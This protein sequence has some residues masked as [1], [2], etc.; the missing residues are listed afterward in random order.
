MLIRFVVSNF[1]SFD[2]ETEFNM[3]AGSLK[4]HKHHVYDA[5]KVEVLKAGAIYGANGAGKSNLI[6]AISFLAEAVKRGNLN[7]SV[8]YQKFKLNETNTQKPVSFEVEIAIEKKIY[9]YG[10]SFQSNHIE[11]EWLYES[12]VTTEDKMIFERKRTTH[13]TIDIVVAKKFQKTEKQKLLIELMKENL[14]KDNE[15]LISKYDNLKIKEITDVYE[16]FKSNLI[17]IFPNSRPMHLIS[18]FLA[19]KHFINN[20]FC[21]FDIGIS[22]LKLTTIDFDKLLEK[23]DQT[24]KDEIKILLDE[25]KQLVP[26]IAGKGIRTNTLLAKE[27]NQYTAKK[28]VTLH[29]NAVNSMI[30]FDIEEESD[31][32][33]RLLDFIPM[34]HSIVNSNR[35]FIIDE[36]E[37]NLHP[38]LIQTL[39]RKIMADA[40][41]KGQLIFT[42]HYVGLMDLDIFRQDEIWFAEKDRNKGSTHLYS[43]NDFK[44]RHD[45]DIEKGY[46]KGRFGAVPFLS[47][48]EQLNWHGHA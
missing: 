19:D 30:E 3:L 22:E 48:L 13:S 37:R 40:S 29:K 18:S 46:L 43:L 20:S 12:G 8:N 25:G 47:D 4:S 32:T 36:I 38:S 42:T 39:I 9:A 33:Q 10:V 23:T 34:F 41:T 1:L 27:N 17:I 2:E 35:I 31:G 26:E 16:W 5:G 15:L 6:K 14:L 24:I 45:L 7:H 11:E 28:L 21:S 44:P